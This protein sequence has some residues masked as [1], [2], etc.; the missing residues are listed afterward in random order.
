MAAPKQCL[1]CE[2]VTWLTASNAKSDGWIS[3]F[4]GYWNDIWR[5]PRCAEGR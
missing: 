2:R 1:D 4:V 3:L 5:C